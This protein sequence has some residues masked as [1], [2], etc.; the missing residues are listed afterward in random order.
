[1]MKTRR[2]LRDFSLIMLLSFIML[3]LILSVKPMRITWLQASIEHLLDDSLAP[4]HFTTKDALFGMDWT[5]LPHFTIALQD[6]AI[7]DNDQQHVAHV[8]EAHLQVS[9]ARLL[10]GHLVI[11]RITLQGASVALRV[12][13][14]GGVR[15]GLSALMADSTVAKESPDSNSTLIDINKFPVRSLTLLDSLLLVQDAQGVQSLPLPRASLTKNDTRASLD[16]TFGDEKQGSSFHAQWESAGESV[17]QRLTGQFSHLPS[18]TILHLL[19]QLGPIQGLSLAINGEF[20]AEMAPDNKILLAD[21][22]LEGMNGSY[23]DKNI[24]PEEIPVDSFKVG[25]HVANDIYT[26]TQL[27]LFSDQLTIHANGTVQKKAD[28]YYGDLQG[29]AQN[30]PLNALYRY[31]P[32]ALAD[33]T[34][35]WVTTNIRDGIAPSATLKVL[36]TPSDLSAPVLPDSVIDAHVNVE[37]ATIT[38]MDR[39]P[40]AKEVSAEV[41]LTGKTME[42]DIKNAILLN[43]MKVNSGK[44][45]INDFNDLTLPLQATLHM[46]SPGADVVTLLGPDHLSIAPSLKLDPA[47]ITGKGHGTLGLDFII[48]PEEAGPVTST[49]SVINYRIDATLEDV[50]QPKV[51]DKWNAEHLNGTF[52]A[53]NEGLTFDATGQLQG[54][55]GIIHVAQNA[56]NGATEYGWKGQLP[57]GKLEEF[58]VGFAQGLSGVIGVEVTAKE[59][60]SLST[61]DATLDLTKTDLLIDQLHYRKPTGQAALMKLA[62]ASPT[63]K[64]ARLIYDYMSLKDRAVGAAELSAAAQDHLISAHANPLRLNGNDLQIE[65]AVSTNGLRHLSLRGP[66][67]NA[68][69]FLAESDS[70]QDPSKSSDDPLQN[71]T[72]TLAIDHLHLGPDQALMDVKGYM[73]CL[74]DF[75]Q[76]ASLTTRTSDNKSLSYNIEMKDGKRALE[77]S[78]ED[79][80]E[81]L[82][83]LHIAEHI[84]GG[85]LSVTGTFDDIQAAHPLNAQVT[86]KDFVLVD[87]PAMTK[88][89]SLL[90]LT[91]LA[92]TVSGKGIRFT[93]LVGD[94]IYQKGDLIITKAK[95]YGPA[96]G[97][98]VEGEIADEGTQL[99]LTGTL[100][101]SYTANSLLGN[102]PL[103][104]SALVGNEGEG[105][106]AARFSVKGPTRDPNV[107]VN[108]LSLLTPGFLRNLFEVVESPEANR[109]K[110]NSAPSTPSRQPSEKPSGSTE[111]V[112]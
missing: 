79:A 94:V 98:T 110:K 38:Y 9:L 2:I 105:V 1:M 107:S 20:R 102:I 97:A 109:V 75:C 76:S 89:L 90:S 67:M 53:N 77:L 85:S 45:T 23:L 30:V 84:R 3:S 62:Y 36:L 71:L 72:L 74:G 73:N 82:R 61:I 95:T 35:T 26:L 64:N 83:A 16:M 39:F 96:I 19:P 66:S 44:V 51:M 70:P 108:P 65:Y 5:P 88:L 104:G 24:L 57:S 59:L 63:D 101:P 7:L 15:L 112:E 27:T 93:K 21:V 13:P 52:T 91:G 46:N 8:P 92:D 103:I 54:V 40:P 86:M 69:P 28:G 111:S 78:S 99:A 55:D 56:A 32:L 58:G 29:G 80:G 41:H 49:A 31:W 37:H 81:M 14:E 25:L 106:F 42:A 47:S 11:G 87:A 12:S 48:Y 22:S 10:Q 50:S 17:P 4:H 43:D 60:P 68:E 33:E 100:V 6:V 34:R 18:Q